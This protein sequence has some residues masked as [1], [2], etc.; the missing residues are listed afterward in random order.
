M[1]TATIAVDGILYRCEAHT[2]L[3]ALGFGVDVGMLQEQ[4]RVAFVRILCPMDFEE[5]EVLAALDEADRVRLALDRFVQNKL[6]VTPASLLESQQKIQSVSGS[7]V[8]TIIAS[9]QVRPNMPLQPIARED[10]HSG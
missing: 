3:W 1:Q 2:Y 10:A 8:T 9:F 6:S 4:I 5:Y 7:G